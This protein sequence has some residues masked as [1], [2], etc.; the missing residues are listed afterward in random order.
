[1]TSMT[2]VTSMNSNSSRIS[3]AVAYIPIIGWLYVFLI[4]RKNGLAL[5]HLRQ[6][7]GLFVFL[8]GVLAIWAVVAWILAW[9]PYAAVFSVA[10]FALV[11]V[12]YVFGVIAWIVGLVRALR[13]QSTPLP[14]F[15]RW[16]ERLPIR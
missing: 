1:M 5:Y 15:G 9:I 6:S 8:I 16:A 12:A 2:S 10:L 4:E 7:I 11:I 14:M 3:A 13:S